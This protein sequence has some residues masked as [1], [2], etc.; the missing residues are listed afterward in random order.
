MRSNVIRKLL[1][2]P[3]PQPAP[4]ASGR[5]AKR[6]WDYQV[7]DSTPFVLVHVAAVVGIVWAIIGAGWGWEPWALCFGLYVVRMFGVTAGYHRYFSHRTYKTS[8]W[9]QFLL[10][11]LAESAVQRGVIW[12]AAHHRDHHKY[13]DEDLDVHSPV[14]HGLWHAQFAWL[15]DHTDFTDYKR[16]SDLSR[17]PELVFLNKL[18]IVPPI[19]LGVACTLWMGWAGALIGFALSTTLLWHGTFT[20]NSLAHIWGKRRYPT[21]DDSRNNVWLA[22]ITLGEGWHNNHHHFMNSTRQ[23]FFWWEIDLAY[24][25]LKVLSWVGLVW[26]LKPPPARVYGDDLSEGVVP[27]GAAPANKPLDHAA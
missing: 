23:G 27:N 10:A 26:D 21:T 6:F 15:Y 25:G 7:L 11:L 3:G 22:L 20:I 18:W 24:Y 4:R 14:R 13:S 16:C 19:L 2:T 17:Y 9:F 8:R 1:F 12:W 5:L